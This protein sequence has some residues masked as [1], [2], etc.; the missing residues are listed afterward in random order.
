[1]TG[2]LAISVAMLAAGIALIVAAHSAA[3]EAPRG[4]TLRV[5]RVTDVDFV[6]LALAYSVWSWPVVYATCAKLFNY[7]D[8]TAPRERG[9]CPRSSTGTRSRRTGGRT[10]ST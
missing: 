7:P 2:R 3:A 8:E 10:L 6:D 5:S 9:S 1:M 4:G